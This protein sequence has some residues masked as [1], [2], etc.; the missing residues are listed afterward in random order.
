MHRGRRLRG[1]YQRA[2]PMEAK[3]LTKLLLGSLR[4][5]MQAARVEEALA[6]AFA[7]PL[8]DIRRAH[9]LLGDIGTTA[10]RAAT[11][12]LRDITLRAHRP[13]HVMLANPATSAEEVCQ[14]L[15][16]PI[17][18]EH[19]YDG[20]R[21]QW[22]LRDGVVRVYSRALEDFTHFF[23]EVRMT[24]PGMSGEWI[25]DGEV[26]AWYEG[27]A[28]SFGTLQRRLGR[29]EVPLTLLLDAPVVFLA[30]DALRA[31]GEDLIDQPLTQRKEFLG[32]AS[33]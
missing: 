22:H 18:A 25:L 9:M 21:A 7:R 29:K 24:P 16:G 28:L 2:T 1:L 14:L 10:E 12:A 26:V 23:P 17:V 33:L 15:Q 13:I 30:F 11:N 8:D 19:K 3:Y 20:I 31:D 32:R 5:G 6:M 4:T 27:Q